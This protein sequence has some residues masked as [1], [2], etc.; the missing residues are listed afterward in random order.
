MFN[1]LTEFYVNKASMTPKISFIIILLTL[2]LNVG[3]SQKTV[4]GQGIWYNHYQ[5]NNPGKTTDFAVT[6]NLD[7]LQ[8]FEGLHYKYSAGEWHFIRCTPDQLHELIGKG[9]IEQIYFQPSY[10]AHLNDTMRLNQNIDSVHSGYSPLQLPYTGK[11]VIVGYV[12]SGLDYTHGDF[13][14]ADGSTRVLYYWDQTLGFDAVLTPGKYGYGQVWDSAA[15]NNGTCTSMDNNAHG[16]TVTGTG[17]GNGLATG[18]FKGA[19][20]ESDII[21]VETNF[22]SPNWTMTVADAVDF[23]F[24]MA[25]TLG[26]PAVVNTSVGD[27]LGSHDG[28]DPAAHVIDSLLMDKPGR[29]VVAAAGNSG[30]QGKYHLKGTATAD[31]SFCW[32][33]VNPSSAFGVPAVYFDMWADTADFNDVYFAFAA[34]NV[35]PWDFRGRTDFY[36]IQDVL[37]TTTYDSIMNGTNKLAPIEFSTQLIG[38]T[39]HLELLISNPDSASYMFRFETFG[40]GEYD[41]W[42]GTFL[43]LS[44]IRSTLMP[45]AIEFPKVVD[46]IYPDSLSTTVSSWTC[47]EKVVTVGNVKNQQDYLDVNNNLYTFTGGPVGKLSVNS[48]KGPNRLGYQKPDVVATGDATLSACPAWLQANLIITNPAMLA[49]GGKHVRN[50]GTSMASPVIAGIAALYLEKC[51][52]A[53][54]QD[55]LDALHTNAFEDFYTGVTPNYAYGYGK[56]NAFG[57]LNQSNF[58]VTLVGDSVICANP[59][60]FQ[61]AENNF[62]SYL[63]QTGETSSS[64]SLSLAD[65]VFVIATNSVGCRSYSDSL[66]VIEGVMPEV[67]VINILGGGLI[68]VAADSLIWYYEG[69]PIA[70]SNSQYYNPDTTGSFSVEVFSADGCS[71]LSDPIY[72]DLSQISELT[73]NEFV[74]F[75][76]PFQESIYLIKNEYHDLEIVITDMVGNVVYHYQTTADDPLF[77]SI[78]LPEIASGTYLVSLFYE[79]SFKS[80]KLI[81]N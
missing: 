54:Y 59:E 5:K 79:N 60:V 55:F 46:Y 38:G 49:Q 21:I 39:Y 10:P 41:L 63:W 50:G 24:S 31:T 71:L 29:I 42:S 18:S 37:N 35:A 56:I 17:S 40:A 36:N 66:V 73:Q 78:D 72:V 34:D 80:T 23:I 69:D 12:D 8:R 20:P 48:S 22:S 15:I 51:P 47:S 76:N 16:T 44:T 33:I 81:K 9:L 53:T 70:N 2:A 61:T 26:K 28:L 62:D 52:E 67:P 30:N 25:D 64:I 58:T 68:T 1:H 4:P 43:G 57:L 13:K 77:M 6:G 19:A 14:N 65:T 3:Y 45:T 11:N 74:L 75:P 27:Y 7:G 32:L